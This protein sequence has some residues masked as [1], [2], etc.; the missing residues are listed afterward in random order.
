MI[1]SHAATELRV[2]EIDCVGRDGV[3]ALHLPGANNMPK[4]DSK[5]SAD[6]N[7]G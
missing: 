4:F 5:A 3:S 1:W 2:V 7:R 6:G